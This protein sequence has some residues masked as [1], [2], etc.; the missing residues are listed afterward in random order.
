[1]SG[2]SAGDIDSNADALSTVEGSSQYRCVFPDKQKCEPLSD[3]HWGSLSVSRYYLWLHERERRPDHGTSIQDGN[4]V[5]GSL[6][7][8][9]G[10]NIE[11]S[12]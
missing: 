5:N 1:M 12:G 6:E 7:C 11:G 10:C 2:T 4:A 8:R 3:V 9:K